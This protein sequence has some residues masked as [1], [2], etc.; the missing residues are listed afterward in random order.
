MSEDKIRIIRI[1]VII[2]LVMVIITGGIIAWQRY[3]PDEKIL[4]L[5]VRETGWEGTV[6]IGGNVSL[7]GYYP[8]S[9][10]D[11]MNS[12]VR[13]AGGIS[14]RIQAPKYSLDIGD[15]NSAQLPQKIDINRAESWLLQALPGIGDTLANRICDYREENGLFKNTQELMSVDGIGPGLYENIESY[16]TVSD[17]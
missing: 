4:I 12:L 2:L 10:N 7:P 13:A 6:Y 1:S 14:S 3:T 17:R 16:I 8:F 5:P 15:K 9:E 11:T